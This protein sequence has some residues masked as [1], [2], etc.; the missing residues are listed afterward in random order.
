MQ[1]RF[2]PRCF[3]MRDLPRIGPL[4]DARATLSQCAPA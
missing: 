2:G 3:G 1:E 4:Y